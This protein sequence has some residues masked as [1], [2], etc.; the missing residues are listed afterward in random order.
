MLQAMAQ[1]NNQEAIVF[2]KRC[3]DILL[4]LPNEVKKNSFVISYLA[5]CFLTLKT[6]VKSEGDVKC[7]L[8]SQTAYLS[9]MCYNI[10]LEAY[11]LTKFED[12]VFWLRYLVV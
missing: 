10:G 12:G 3:K 6:H 7:E 1:G 4:R 8:S 9:L 11:S 2:I 5:V